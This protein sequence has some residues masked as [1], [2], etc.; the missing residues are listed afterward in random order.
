MELQNISK[1]KRK[2][3]YDDLYRTLGDDK[4]VDYQLLEKS[5]ADVKYDVEIFENF[6][7]PKSKLV[8]KLHRR[9]LKNNT[10]IKELRGI[11]YF[12]IYL[13]II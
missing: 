7:S 4:K 10:L 12:L 2:R 5:L 8:K 11:Q 1:V 9:K 13:T 3:N 6:L